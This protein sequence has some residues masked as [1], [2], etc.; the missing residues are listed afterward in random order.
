MERYK[1]VG[2]FKPPRAA[3]AGSS[4]SSTKSQTPHSL[5]KV[6]QPSSMRQRMVSGMNKPKF[7]VVDRNTSSPATS[8][9]AAR[10]DPYRESIGPEGNRRK[11]PAASPFAT[12]SARYHQLDREAQKAT[13]EFYAFRKVGGELPKSLVRQHKDVYV[14]DPKQTREWHAEAASV[15]RRAADQTDE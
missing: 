7:G 4:A 12:S 14:G 3:S 11:P 5:P 8:N 2:E 1:S 13:G 9:P 6:S 10:S 15:A